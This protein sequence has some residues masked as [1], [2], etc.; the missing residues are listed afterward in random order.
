MQKLFLQKNE[1]L[2]SQSLPCENRGTDSGAE[3][4]CIIKNL[5]PKDAE[6]HREKILQGDCTMKLLKVH[7]HEYRCLKDV[8]INFERDLTPQVFPIGGENGSGKSTLLQLIFALLHCPVH[9]VRR[10][11]LNHVIQHMKS[12]HEKWELTRHGIA[13]IE[14]LYKNQ[15]DYNGFRGGM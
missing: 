14:L 7:V 4:S 13:T 11:F 3:I 10:N 5:T 6:E 15:P 1:F 2:R 9:P 8:V 12:P